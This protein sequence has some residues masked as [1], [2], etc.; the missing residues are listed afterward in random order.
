MRAAGRADQPAGGPSVEAGLALDRH[1]QVDL[2]IGM[3]VVRAGDIVHV[4]HVDRKA[5]QV[6]RGFED[7]AIADAGA[8]A[9]AQPAFGDAGFAGGLQRA[10]GFGIGAVFGVE[11]GI[12]RGVE[13][14]A[15]QACCQFGQLLAEGLGGRWEGGGHRQVLRHVG[16]KPNRFARLLLMHYCAWAN[17][18]GRR[19]ACQ[20]LYC[21]SIG[22]CA[23]GLPDER[24]QTGI[25]M[26]Y[27]P[28]APGTAYEVKRSV[29]AIQV[30]AQ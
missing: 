28:L 3:G 10:V 9:I 14:T 6:V 5:V 27:P 23:G 21:R 24:G 26:T 16:G 18:R 25:V 12:E 4:D 7:A 22:G 20:E 2:A 15:G 11:P 29:A 19:R 1:D 30:Y 17:H 13:R 8:F